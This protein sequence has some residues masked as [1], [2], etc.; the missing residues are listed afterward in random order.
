MVNEV[1]KETVHEI[2]GLRNP[3]LEIKINQV[4]TLALI[5]TG[6]SVSLLS[7]KLVRE[8]LNQITQFKNEVSDAS[9]NRIPILGK[10]QCEVDTPNGVISET[11]LVYKDAGQMK[12]S[13]ILGMNLLKRATID[14]RKKRVNFDISEVNRP[15]SP[16]VLV[17]IPCGNIINKSGPPVT[18][19]LRL[20][21]VEKVRERKFSSEMTQHCT[22][23][24]EVPG[25]EGRDH[26]PPPTGRND[27][28]GQVPSEDLHNIHLLEDLV[29]KGNTVTIAPIKVSKKLENKTIMVHHAEFK[30]GVVSANVVATHT[31]GRILLNMINVKDHEV[32]LKQGTKI[33]N[34]TILESDTICSVDISKS[35][36]QAK[37]E[38]EPRALTME[39]VHCENNAA[40][41]PLLNLLNKYR[42][43]CW[44]PGEPL[45]LYKGEPLEINLKEPTIVN[46]APYRIPHAK[47]QKLDKVIENMLSEGI[48]TR[49]KSSFNSPLIIVEKADGEIRPCIDF[50][51]LNQ[52]TIPV[53]FPIPRISDLLSTLGKTKII[54]SL[55][56]ASAYHQCEIKEED[57][58]KTAFT[59]RQTRYEFA[60]V[61]FG[62]T[63]A[64][65]YFSRVI[66]QVLFEI[67]GPNCC[68]AYLDDILVFAK[69]EEEHFKRLEQVLECL[70][71][72]NIKL[73]LS[74][75]RFFTQEV[76]FLGY[77]ISEQGMK[78]D[79]QRAEAIRKMPYPTNKRGLQSLLGAINYY[80][81][82]VREFAKIA[83][84]LY[85]LL[86]KNAKFE[87]GI[88]QSN[89][90]DEL[91]KRLSCTPILKFPDF[92]KEFILHTD[93]SLTGIG[94]CLMQE[95]EDVLHPVSF[96]S[97]CL[98]ETQRAYS[99]TKREA[100]ALIYGLEQ[101]RHLILCYPVHVFTDHYPLLGILA[102]TT[103][104]PCLTRWAL[105]VQEYAIKL[106]YLPG[107]NNLFADVLSRLTNK[108]QQAEQIPTELDEK[109]SERINYCY[110]EELQSFIPEKVPWTEKELR[111]A[112]KKDE[113]CTK[114][115][116]ALREER[117]ASPKAANFK[118]IMG[119]LFV[120]RSITR[121]PLTDEFIVPYIPEEL[122]KK[123]FK[124]I[125]EET[126]AGHK[127][128]DRTLKMFRK[129]F[130]NANESKTLKEW[131][132]QCEEC[133]KAKAISKN[134]P[135]EKYPIPTQP[136]H[137][138]S[139]DI[140]GP[141]PITEG[142]H[143][144]IL[145]VRD[146]T[147]RYTILRA[148]EN[149]DTDSII[150]EVRQVISHYG[151]NTVFITDNAQEYL[152]EKFKKFLKFYNTRK[153]EIAPYHPASQGLSERINREVN[154]LLRIYTNSLA[155]NNWDE[156]L[157]VLQLTINNTYNASLGETPFF[158]LYGYDSPTIT[159]SPP[160]IDYSEDDLTARLTR[161]SQIRRHCHEHLLK[162]Q[163]KYTE[164]TN[165]NR[166]PKNISI[167]QRVFAKLNKHR[168]H[169]KLDYPVSGPMRV[170][171][172][173]G[174]AF[175]LKD[176]T[177]GKTFLV[178]PD[179]ILVRGGT[180]QPSRGCEG[181]NESPTQKESKK[182]PRYNLRKR[183]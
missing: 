44:L 153:V 173:K 93:A 127:G 83:D 104:D 128:Y 138:V 71:K 154:K 74:K 78:M 97:K 110:C 32:I 148:L 50:R 100:L 119:L 79:P 76:K 124:V 113:E 4:K 51:A 57:R 168:I 21:A 183:N 103:K 88:R 92:E 85:E 95:H 144:Y 139:S 82:F 101:F 115:K 87:W 38:V 89:A 171:S 170:I 125:H 158:A 99:T 133:I 34:A 152:A 18:Q 55:D 28:T 75:C 77:R 149:K 37:V 41:G 132:E 134:V 10:L 15:R 105:L 126:T 114:L 136:F 180:D 22:L 116:K 156:L 63:S 61:P 178:H 121:G 146:F 174:K 98:T 84:P 16:G 45:G 58:E 7:E 56:L 64:P 23:N 90:V 3:C 17:S 107:K 118:I 129:N 172:K 120:Y 68:L 72:A 52:V 69:D 86:R 13:A 162:E 106:H 30:E 26:P 43:T 91:K 80:R 182:E 175:N 155:I 111:E 46:K 24:K 47:Q 73:K 160:K 179:N 159:F 123:A 181:K 130:Y 27:E 12:I 11:M 31:K 60:R 81:S 112:Q 35:E 39:D 36:D 1:P 176:E 19:G 67:L 109:L 42:K 5:D 59:V 169:H 166:K 163:V 131:C 165:D 9:G 137:T 96:V 108:E 25:P 141:L 164:A 70:E 40:K 142:N 177:S 147:T 53:T 140:L 65:G 94:A 122:M 66:N 135:I 102:K 151:S 62:L 8:Q 167:N 145:V 6:A 54:T 14:L 157:P 2:E 161:V 117:K 29:L 48:I 150:E 20:E 33:G 49:S 143:R